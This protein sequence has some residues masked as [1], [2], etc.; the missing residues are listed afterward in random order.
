MNNQVEDI[1]LFE[2]PYIQV[3]Q[4]DG[5][6]IYRSAPWCNSTGVAVLPFRKV[7]GLL[8]FLG[9]FE[10]RP[11]HDK[12]EP[13]KLRLYSITGGYDNSDVFTVPQCALNELKEEAG[14]VTT[15]R[16]LIPLG[17]IMPSKESDTVVH[18]FGLNLDKAEY[19]EVQATGDGSRGEEGAYCDWVNVLQLGASID[20]MLS[21]MYLRLSCDNHL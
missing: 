12:D 9:R 5:Y 6:Y 2:N 10:H 16:F 21:S 4:R 17:S 7:A 3:H 18:L 13:G 19:E 14:I 1:V 11:C 15:E 8:Q 20:P